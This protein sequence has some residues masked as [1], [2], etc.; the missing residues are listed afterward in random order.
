M[1]VAIA[2]RVP[3]K[4]DPRYGRNVRIGTL[5]SAGNNGVARIGSS[6]GSTIGKVL[7]RIDDNH[8]LAMVTLA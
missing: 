8:V 6:M 7:K 2:G 3:V 4:I 5:L 1:L